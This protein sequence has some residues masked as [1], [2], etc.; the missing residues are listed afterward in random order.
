MAQLRDLS[1]I[2][3]VPGLARALDTLLVTPAMTTAM[4]TASVSS[5]GVVTVPK[6]I[7]Q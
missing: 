4:T 3:A 2:M 7:S 1:E 6:D 5:A